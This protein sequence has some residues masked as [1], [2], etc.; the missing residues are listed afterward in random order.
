M[1]VYTCS[2]C[3][4]FWVRGTLAAGESQ[5]PSL[6]KRQS[7]SEE[8][9]W[10]KGNG[11]GREKE[12][13]RKRLREG[14]PG[15]HSEF[16]ASQEN[17]SHNQTKV[18]LSLFSLHVWLTPLLWDLGLF[19]FLPSYLITTCRIIHLSSPLR[20]FKFNYKFFEGFSLFVFVEA[21]SP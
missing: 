5:M 21:A 20:E 10:D 11:E 7:W 8:F 16:Q 14:E 19:F 6:A 18:F 13:E 1:I 12:K 2:Y 17:L 15:L 3:K 4:D 9:Y